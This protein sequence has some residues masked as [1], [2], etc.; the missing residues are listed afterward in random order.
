MN[1]HKQGSA[2]PFAVPESVIGFIGIVGVVVIADEFGVVYG[3]ITIV[4]TAAVGRIVAQGS[5]RRRRG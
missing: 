1:R 3:V 4:V 2:W 5:N